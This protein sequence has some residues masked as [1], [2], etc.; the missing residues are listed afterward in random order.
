MRDNYSHFLIKQGLK[1]AGIP[2]RILS[3]DEPSSSLDRPE[4]KDI[5]AYIRLAINTA[6]TPALIRILEGRWDL[7]VSR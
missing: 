2:A 3:E 5:L 7:K 6:H 1:D 4:I